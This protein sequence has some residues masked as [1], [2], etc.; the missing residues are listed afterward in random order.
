MSCCSILT[1][2]DKLKGMAYDFPQ[3]LQDIC[4][5]AIKMGK[6]DANCPTFLPL[7]TFNLGT[8]KNKN[9]VAAGLPKIQKSKLEFRTRFTG[10]QKG[11]RGV[12]ECLTNWSGSEKVDEPIRLTMKCY[13][14]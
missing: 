10:L 1:I 2:E 3:A 5:A 12:L 11:S 9:S 13:T 4:P 6:N 7:S 8:S 14:L